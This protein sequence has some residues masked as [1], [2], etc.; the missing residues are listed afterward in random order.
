MLRALGIPLYMWACREHNPDMPAFTTGEMI[1][2]GFMLIL[3]A[4]AV[5]AMTRGIIHV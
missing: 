5:Y 4:F 1:I 3:A 2:A